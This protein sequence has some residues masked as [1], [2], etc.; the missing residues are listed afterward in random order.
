[1]V[2]KV[3]AAD[4]N[5]HNEGAMRLRDVKNGQSLIWV[6]LFTDTYTP[7][8]VIREPYVNTEPAQIASDDD[9]IYNTMLVTL[10]D[11]TGQDLDFYPEVLGLMPF[12]WDN[13]W[14]EYRYLLPARKAHLLPEGLTQVEDIHRYSAFYEPDPDEWLDDL[15]EDPY[16]E[17]LDAFLDPDPEEQAHRDL[18]DEL[19]KSDPL[20]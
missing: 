16:G 10:R 20:L 4:V 3:D 12:E 14:D 7:V 19:S 1:M 8:R 18:L 6:N 2:R 17:F 9:T 11:G 15:M 13:Q 5:P